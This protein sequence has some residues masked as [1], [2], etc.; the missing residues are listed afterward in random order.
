MAPLSERKIDLPIIF[1]VGGPGCGKGTQ[2]ERIVQKFDF[3]HLSSGDLLRNEVNSG[4]ELGKQLK[5]TMDA[6]GLVPLDKVLAIVKAAMLKE[7]E[8]SKGF[9]IDDATG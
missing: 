4:S 6:G 5:E 2:C 3:T 9:L 8:T 1:I 7:C